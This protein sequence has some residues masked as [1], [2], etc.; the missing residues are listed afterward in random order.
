MDT[1][2]G[3]TDEEKGVIDSPS[4]FAEK[5]GGDNERDWKPE[6]QRDSSNPSEDWLTDPANPFNWSLAK[7]VYHLSVPSLL[8]FVC[9][10]GSSIYASGSEDVA[11]YFGVSLVAA[12]LGLSL[13]ILGLA[14]GP[15]IAAPLSEAFGRRNVYTGAFAVSGL[16][17]LGV[18]LSRNFGS[19]LVCRF[20]AGFFSGPVLAVGSGVVADVFPPIHRGKTMPIFIG[21]GFFGPVTAVILGGFVVEN[22]GWRWLQWVLLFA[23]AGACIYILP[24]QETYKATILKARQKHREKQQ[25]YKE[26]QLSRIASFR[27]IDTKEETRKIWRKTVSTLAMTVS[28]PISLLFTE[29]ILFAVTLYIAFIFGVFYGFLAAFPYVFETVYKFNPGASGLA[30]VG[31]LVGCALGLAI[32]FA[33]DSFIYVPKYYAA[34]SKGDINNLQPE[35]RL[36]APM[37]SSIGIPISL[38]WFGWTADKDVHWIS[39]IIASVF[40]S[41]GNI[42]VFNCGCLYL[43]D[44]Y[45]ALLGASALA[46][47]GLARYL[48]AAAFPLFVRQ[49]FEHLGIGWASSLLGFIAATLFPIPFVLFKYGPKLRARSMRDEVQ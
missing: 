49:M 46:A 27:S 43:I 29:P 30:W 32:I 47:N 48:L 2:K 23:V 19:V 7:R 9:T 37:L 44:T 14:F 39:P 36:Y 17:T 16:F 34:I 26:G 31:L 42:C 13:Y 18:G 24:T 21:T 5:R 11:S 28:K 15:V 1:P 35:H 33:C 45:G 4:K 22:K 25:D 10:F 3:T 8:C 41:M 20:F 12:D 38:F 40:F 6:Q